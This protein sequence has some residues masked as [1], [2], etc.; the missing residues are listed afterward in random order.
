MTLLALEP[1]TPGSEAVLRSAVEHR[2]RAAGG[3][4][5]RR[6]AWQVAAAVAGEAEHL[7]NVAFADASHL[8]KIEVRGG[9]APADSPDRA[10]IEVGPG[11]WIVLCAWEQR[12]PLVAEL[13]EGGRRLVLDLSGA[14]SVL[15]LAGPRAEQLL[16]R[17]GPIAELPGAGPIAA[18]P[19]RVTRRGELLWVLVPVEYAQ[20]V[21]D[22]C[23]DLCL[24]LEGGPAGLDAVARIAD[25][26]LLVA[27]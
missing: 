16:R 24:P 15:L 13:N 26:P 7:G 23:A 17:L 14:W 5:E 25:D 20:H 11:R 22:V 27:P 1:W 4:I 18:V 12:A 6:G 21:W 10:V 19:G 2:L 8:G 3:R 9:T